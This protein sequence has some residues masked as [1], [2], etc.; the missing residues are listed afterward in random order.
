MIGK[1]IGRGGDTIKQ[2]QFSSGTRI[3]ID[4]DS[5][6]ESK[7]VNITGAQV[8]QPPASA[9]LLLHTL[10]LHV[11]SSSCPSTRRRQVHCCARV[12]GMHAGIPS[13]VGCN[14]FPLHVL[15][16]CCSPTEPLYL[17][18]AAT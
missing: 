2:L 9:A 7:R 14:A 12:H 6:V 5:G 8:Q 18:E 10:L 15:A 11:S 13:A 3:Q 16:T 17:P 1:L 4:H